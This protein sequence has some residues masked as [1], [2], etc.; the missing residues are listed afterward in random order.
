MAK[1]D[2][3]VVIAYMAGILAA[4]FWARR[5][6][7]TQDQFL[8]A[9]R[10]VGP[11]LYSGTLAAIVLGGASTVGGVKLGYQYGISGMWLVFMLG[12][13]I[14]VLSVVFVERILGLKLYTVPELLE[15]RYNP[16]AR[17]VGGVV[18]VAYDLMVSVT[19]TIAVGSVMEVIVGIP[20]TAAIFISSG[21]MVAYSVLGG[22]WSLTLTDIIQFV[23]KTVG[24]LF[25]LLPGAIL[26]AGGL[27]AM[28]ARLPAEWFSLTHIGAGK[29]LSFFAL[30]FFG[31]II[32][33]DVWQRVFTARSVKVAR[34][35]G[36]AVG[37]YCLCYALAGAMIGT[38]GRVFLPPLANA[39][40]AFAQ[41]VEAVLPVGLRGLVLAAALAAIMSTASACLLAAS[42]VLLEDVYLRL[43]GALNAGSVAQS[44]V[45]TLGLGAV[46]TLLSCVMHDVIAA[47]TV[48]YDFLVGGLLVP[49]IGAMMWRRGTTAGALASIAAGATMVAVLLAAD[50]I[51][52]DLPIYA[53]LGAS[54]I[55]YV[56]VSVGAGSSAARAA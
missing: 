17:V 51:D 36:I 25:I 14:I 8:V 31:I 42:T 29:I 27:P 23:I 56:A 2:L 32:G 43:R 46:M 52:S 35:G 54:L 3:L 30:Y 11:W 21:V 34:N 7:T 20:R 18:M 53:G 55:A 15:R 44:R 39:D 5:K 38:A 33:Q 26:H 4:G 28:H 45:V 49:V 1:L 10:S 12:L 19:A 47:L 6:A 40:S 50:G 41:I 13:G 24:I 9:G 37:V 22:M 48:A 16:S